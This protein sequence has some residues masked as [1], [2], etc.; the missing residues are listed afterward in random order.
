M[1]T[2]LKFLLSL[3]MIS[4]LS[5]QST[6]AQQDKRAQTGFKFM[7][8]SLDPRGAAL[9]DAVTSL[10]GGSEM[11]F[12][13]PAGMANQESKLSANFG[14]MTWIADIKYNQAG[15]SFKMGNAGVVGFSMMNVDYG[16]FQET[17][18][19]ETDAQ[20][21]IDIGTFRPT[22]MALGVG[23][24]RALTDRF[25]IGGNVKYV[26]Q[27]LG[28]A[29]TKFDTGIN[30]YART[31]YKKSVPAFDFGVQYK[32]G[33][34]SLAFAF[35]ARNFSK[36]VSFQDQT[37]QL[38][39]TMKMGIS[40]NVLDLVG[41]KN[42]SLLVSLDAEHPRDYAEQIKIGGEYSLKNMFFLRAGYSYPSDLQGFSFGAGIKQKLGGL[43]IGADYAYTQ[44]DVFKAVH[45]VG[46]KIG[47]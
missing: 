32:T 23:Y 25:A 42:Q 26:T 22:A 43:R 40:M 11:L 34:K 16:E 21:Y 15:V 14:Q 33:Y 7:S 37:F 3:W 45:R 20:G 1:K 24:A 5:P 4:L 27:N 19:S 41:A 44:F 6:F 46:F 18:R 29:I 35:N 36:E 12:Y 2:C 10:E 28:S 38:P 8:V 31:S 17:I 47:F 9:G 30:D 13:N 39:L